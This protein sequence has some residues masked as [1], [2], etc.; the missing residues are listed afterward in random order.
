MIKIASVDNTKNRKDSG[1]TNDINYIPDSQKNTKKGSPKKNINIVK[2]TTTKFV[3]NNDEKSTNSSEYSNSSLPTFLTAD[4]YDILIIRA[5]KLIMTNNIDALIFYMED[6]V[7]H[8][9]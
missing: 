5:A 7:L 6:N 4:K 9:P 1:N 8:L 2:K 3:D